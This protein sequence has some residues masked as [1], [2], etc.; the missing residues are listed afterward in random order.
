MAPTVYFS[1]VAFNYKDRY[2]LTGSF[3]RDGSSVF[4]SNNRWGNFY[5]VGATWNVTEEAF[6]QS[7]NVLSLLK[8]R[9]SYGENGNALGFGFYQALPTYKYGANYLGLPGSTLGNVGY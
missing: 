5:S 7:V 9:A 2:V 8:L 1:N 3:R 6:M 4:G